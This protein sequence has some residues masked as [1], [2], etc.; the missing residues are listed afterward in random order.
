VTAKDR[1]RPILYPPTSY[2]DE[3]HNI[4]IKQRGTSG[5]HRRE[6]VQGSLDWAQTRVFDYDPFPGIFK[7][8]AA[9]LYA[10]VMDH[11]F[12]DGNK[13]TALMTASFFFFINGYTLNIPDN[14]PEFTVSIVQM[15]ARQGTLVQDEIDR[16]ARWLELQ[17]STPRLWRLLYRLIRDSLPKDASTD[18]LFHHP[19]WNRYYNI[20]KTETTQRFKAL[21]AR[22]PGARAESNGQ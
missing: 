21:L 11:A 1:E 18:I 14:S 20:W 17:V 15:A 5:Y 12:L 7:R 2:V 9:I 10:Y 13:R 22:W 3:F 4:L 8:A 6:M 16:I 19:A